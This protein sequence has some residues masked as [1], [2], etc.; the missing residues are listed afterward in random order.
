ME[1][2]KPEDVGMK[3]KQIKKKDSLP[4]RPDLNLPDDIDNYPGNNGIFHFLF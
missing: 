2:V 3:I 1:V 4:P